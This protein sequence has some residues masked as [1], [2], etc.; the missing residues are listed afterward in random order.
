MTEGVVVDTPEGSDVPINIR[1]TCARCSKNITE[2]YAEERIKEI[3]DTNTVIGDVLCPTCLGEFEKFKKN[4]Y[5][6][7]AVVRFGHDRGEIV[8]DTEDNFENIE[9]V[10][11]YI[12]QSDAK[13]NS[14]MASMGYFLRDKKYI[15]SYIPFA[16][17]RL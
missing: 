10:N 14:V 7:R 9:Q 4:A 3:Y 1:Y 5:R 6:V 13:I 8:E 2:K 12:E 15:V 11:N 17:R 16:E